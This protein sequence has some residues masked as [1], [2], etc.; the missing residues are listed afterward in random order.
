MKRNIHI[1]SALIAA[2]IYIILTVYK[3][4]STT[5]VINLLYIL[6]PASIVLMSIL[7]ALLPDM[8][9]WIAIKYHRSIITHSMLIPCILWI[10]VLIGM[11]PHGVYQPIILGFGMH[12]FMDMF[13]AS[14]LKTTWIQTTFSWKAPACLRLGFRHSL[15]PHLSQTILFITAL[16][17][18]FFMISPSLYL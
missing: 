9:L 18:V 4:Y 16:L 1:G 15:G 11:E 17:C 7:G 2:L 5:T 6:Q 13:P 10:T 8:D 12:L 14:T 3:Y